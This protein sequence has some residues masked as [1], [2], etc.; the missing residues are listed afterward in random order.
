LPLVASPSHCPLTPPLLLSCAGWLLHCLSSCCPLVVPP[1]CCAALSAA[2]SSCHP[3][4]LSLSSHWAALLLSHLTGCLLR[5]LSLQCPPVVLSLHRSFVVL[6]RLV[7]A[8]PL[9]ALP[10]CPLVVP[11]SRPLVVLY[12]KLVKPG[13]PDPFDVTFVVPRERSSRKS[14]AWPLEHARWSRRRDQPSS[15]N[16]K[17]STLPCL[18]QSYSS[19]DTSA[20]S[21]S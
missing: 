21:A 8:L 6:R 14:P 11:H 13:F 5:R 4:I 7:V 2:L 17:L 16:R 1:S 10:S 18:A 20:R 3:L 12:L 19:P 9:V 15:M